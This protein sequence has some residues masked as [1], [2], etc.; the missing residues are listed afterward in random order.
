MGGTSYLK[1]KRGRASAFKCLSHYASASPPDV[2][3]VGASRLSLQC[4]W[5]GSDDLLAAEC[6]GQSRIRGA[7]LIHAH[8]RG[9]VPLQDYLIELEAKFNFNLQ[10]IEKIE[11]KRKWGWR[12][13]EKWN[14]SGQFHDL[15]WCLG[16]WTAIR[17]PPYRVIVQAVESIQERVLRG[18]QS[19]QRIKLFIARN[20][21]FRLL[22]DPTNSRAKSHREKRA[23]DL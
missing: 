4:H 3:M 7:V 23:Y 8:W 18:Q 20:P 1:C 22:L 11:K 2:D 12:Q 15:A 13:S 21:T 19:R 10:A 14:E 16:Y 6:L 9:H 5:L 17:S